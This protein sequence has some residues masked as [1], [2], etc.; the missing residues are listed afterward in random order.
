M[1]RY[2]NMDITIRGC[3]SE[4]ESGVMNA[5]ED[6]WPVQDWDDYEDCDGVAILSA[7][8]RSS[9]CAGESEEEF[10]TRVA[11]AV[12][13]ANG[14]FCEV[15]VDATYLEC[16]PCT[17]HTRT[18]RDYEKSGLTPRPLPPEGTSDENHVNGGG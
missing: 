3:D 17:S 8:A 11:H 10:T 18:I 16:A 2:Y 14:Q 4:R 9:L 5:V 13:E 12:W 7:S 6:I 1:S 15:C